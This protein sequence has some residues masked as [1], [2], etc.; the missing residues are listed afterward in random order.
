MKKGKLVSYLSLIFCAGIL[1]T[2]CSKSGG[3]PTPD[4]PPEL[5]TLNFTKK[6]FV[7][8]F[9]GAWCGWCP[10]MAWSLDS[11]RK[12]NPKVIVAAV[13]DDQGNPANDPFNT[14]Y[15]NQ[16]EDLV[17][18]FAGFPTGFVNRKIITDQF[19][20]AQSANSGLSGT[21][22]AGL[23]IESSI[24]GNILS[25][26]VTT[27]FASNLSNSTVNLAVMLVEDSLLSTQHNY[28][29][30]S[31]YV[32][33]TSP[34]WQNQVLYNWVNNGVLRSYATSVSGDPVPADKTTIN[35]DTYTKNVSFSL[36]SY[37]PDHCRII[38]IL[39]LVN[40]SSTEVLNAQDVK[41]GENQLFD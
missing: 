30:H 25:A 32:A 17:P 18:G 28:Y 13:H 35:N 20:I 37:N 3:G 4:G 16:V 39:I 29:F 8:D 6:V 9:T 10:L 1:M 31:A 2:A 36:A 27:G 23:Q 41:A 34:L 26:K 14:S 21:A 19:N 15:T 38:A 22:K 7:E 12:V 40:G 5:P 33:P 11:M 24:S